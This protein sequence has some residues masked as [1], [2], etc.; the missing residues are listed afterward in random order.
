MAFQPRRAWGLGICLMIV[1]SLVFTGSTFASAALA[2][3]PKAE[4]LVQ[5]SSGP[6]TN[7]SSQHQTEVEPDTFSYGSTIVS[8]LIKRPV[9]MMHTLL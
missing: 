6:Y 2:T 7:K 1:L 8:A 9:A 4:K 5:L 3:T